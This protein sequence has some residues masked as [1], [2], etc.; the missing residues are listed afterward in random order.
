MYVTGDTL[1][2]FPYEQ[3]SYFFSSYASEFYSEMPEVNMQLINDNFQLISSEPL[4]RQ[5]ERGLA[6]LK[7]RG[8]PEMDSKD[9]TSM[10]DGTRKAYAGYIITYYFNNNKDERKTYIIFSQNYTGKDKEQVWSELK[11]YFS[12]IVPT[13]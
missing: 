3:I 8:I 11:K 12:G 4:N 7:K 10:D 1:K 13:K 2:L 9:H 6:A 5:T